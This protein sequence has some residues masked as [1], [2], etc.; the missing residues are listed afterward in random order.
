MLRRRIQ[1]PT[2]AQLGKCR[3]EE[4]LCPRAIE[5]CC[6][7]KHPVPGNS[8]SRSIRATLIVYFTPALVLLSALTVE[9][10]ENGIGRH[11][12][13]DPT[14][15]PARGD[16]QRERGRLRGGAGCCPEIPG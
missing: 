14:Q 12:G 8:A 7:T 4:G 13:E 3:A 15:R 1:L 2:R 11:R 6:G 10:G 16:Q 9:P 5:F